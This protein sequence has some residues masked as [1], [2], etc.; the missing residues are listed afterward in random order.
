MPYLVYCKLYLILYIVVLVRKILI[1]SKLLP[2]ISFRWVIVPRR[3]GV[4]L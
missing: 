2:R 1:F 3:T 4:V